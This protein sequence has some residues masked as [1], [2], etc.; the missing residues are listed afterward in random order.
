[1]KR[2]SL[3]SVVVLICSV[4]FL[5]ACGKNF[6]FAGRNLPPSGVANRVLVAV[7]NPS[8]LT[9]GALLFDDALYD[10]RHAYNNVNKTFSIGGFAGALPVTIQNMPEQQVGAVYSIGDGSLTTVSYATEK[11]LSS[12]AAGNLNGISQSIFISRDLSYIYAA[13]QSAHSLTVLDHG[14]TVTLNVPG[15][16]RVSVN[17]GNTGFRS[18]HE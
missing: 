18:E 8:A 1:L 14:R 4:S 13:S 12:T 6:Y 15:V 2:R 7:Q 16:Y 5:T 10:I 11:V 3:L 17:P 9:K